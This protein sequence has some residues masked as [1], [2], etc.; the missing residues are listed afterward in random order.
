MRPIFLALLFSARAQPPPLSSFAGQPQPVTSC[1]LSA[2]RTKHGFPGITPQQCADAGSCF[3]SSDASQPWCFYPNA[4]PNWAAPGPVQRYAGSQAAP[5]LASLLGSVHAAE[6]GDVAGVSCL[7]APPLAQSCDSITAAAT[8]VLAWPTALAVRNSTPLAGLTFQWAPAELRRWAS[9][10]EGAPGSGQGCQVATALRLSSSQP[11]LMLLQV[12][13]SA[14]SS[15]S[16]SS[17]SP[18]TLS[19]ALPAHISSMPG[20][21]TWKRPSPPPNPAA[22]NVSLQPAAAAGGGLVALSQDATAASASAVWAPGA[23]AVAWGLQEGLGAT[24]TLT[25]PSGLQAASAG[26]VLAVVPVGA[27]APPAAAAA[28]AVAAAAAAAAAYPAA[29]A[30]PV[31]DWEALWSAA[32]TPSN[33][34]FSGSLPPL[35]TSSPLARPYY[36]GI[37]SLLMLLRRGAA[38]GAYVLP[39]AGPV[40]AVTDTYLWDASLA[41]TVMA[42]L[43]PRSWLQDTLTP[44]LSIDT[45]A[46]YARDYLSG[47]GVGPWYSFN[48]IALFT[49][50]DKYGRATG[51]G[52]SSINVAFY[53]STLA[54]RRAIEWMDSAATYWQGL[55]APNSTLADYGLAYNLLECVPTYLHCVPS[56]NAANVAM[57]QRAAA[58][59]QALGNASRAAA[60]QASAAALLPEVLALYRP[61]S[62]TWDCAYPGQQRV[63]VR[64]V[65]DFIYTADS[66]W[67]ALAPAQRAEMAQFLRSELLLPGGGW[68]RALSLSDAAA[69]AS[70]RADHGPLGSY[71][72]WPPL[73]ARALGQLGFV[74]E[75]VA[76]L[77]GFAGPQG[78]LSEGCFGQAHRVLVSNFSSS[79]GSVVVKQGLTGGQDFFESAGGAFAEAALELLAM[80]QQ[81]QED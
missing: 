76:L 61:G 68:L 32:F 17:S 53:N 78:V 46:H 54:G 31:S 75:G 23:Q 27:G 19:M 74:Q 10:G 41:A 47:Q 4:T 57:M 56:L 40:W 13:V 20:P 14:C 9:V 29:F 16:S 77:A 28:A 3:D 72:G 11:L 50:L 62:G 64:T 42:L 7:S 60:L 24:L 63:N 52:S 69:S 80:Q 51:S 12:N 21:W 45:H 1:W 58:V 34:L 81:L 66:L 55:V 35:P 39:T 43:E 49:L 30:Q 15:S 70:D 38:P 2:P 22:Y 65:I 8:P 67:L 79:A 48:D 44:L 25:W 5:A 71:D 59:W 18:L 6:S 26:L 37:L 33:S 36:A 73:A